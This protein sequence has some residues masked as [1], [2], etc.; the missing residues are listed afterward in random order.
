MLSFIGIPA[1]GL[2]T[3]LTATNGGAITLNLVDGVIEGRDTQ[4]DLVLTI[5]IVGAPGSEQIQTT[6]FEALNHGA[7]D[8]LFDTELQLLL[9]GA[10]VVQLQYSV[11]RTDGDG[12]AITRTATI[13]LIT[14]GRARRSR[15]MT[16]ARC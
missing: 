14:T 7:D 13:D 2:A 16:T 8:N 5:A 9:S 15:S 4:N 12:D 6:L 10:G 3:N 11:T 1:G